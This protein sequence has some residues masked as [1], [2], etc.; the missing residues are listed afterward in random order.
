MENLLTYRPERVKGLGLG[1]DNQIFLPKRV[2]YIAILTSTILISVLGTTILVSGIC[3]VEADIIR[4]SLVLV[5]S[6]I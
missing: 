5:T 2:L 3:A 6:A 1:L 4:R